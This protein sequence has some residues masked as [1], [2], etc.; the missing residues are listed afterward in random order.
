MDITTE[1]NC[2]GEYEEKHEECIEC[3]YKNECDKMTPGYA[4]NWWYLLPICFGLIGGVVASII[5][6]HK[7][8]RN[9][10]NIPILI[11]VGIFFSCVRFVGLFGQL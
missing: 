4:S 9:N 2:F 8:K 10:K 7:H 5:V 6:S 3:D 11:L 1:D